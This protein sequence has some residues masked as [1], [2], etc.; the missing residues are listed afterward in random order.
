MAAFD[1][2]ITAPFGDGDQTFRL[3]LAQLLELQEKAD[4]GPMELLA[5]LRGISW[6]VQDV[7]ETVRLGLIGGGMSPPD[8]LRLVQ[9]YVDGR[10]LLESVPIAALVL[11]AALQGP[12]EIAPGK[13][14]ATE[15]TGASPPPPYTDPAPSLGSGPMSSGA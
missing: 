7:R 10:P 12:E 8:A 4:A 2:G 3:A 15:E 11:M 14:E 1:G 5:R 6:R 9:R 13:A